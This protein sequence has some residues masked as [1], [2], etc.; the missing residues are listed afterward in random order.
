MKYTST[1]PDPFWCSAFLGLRRFP[2]HDLKK[3]AD[4]V[5]RRV[6]VRQ[7]SLFHR[8]KHFFRGEISHGG[9]FD[10]SKNLGRTLLG[11]PLG[12]T[13]QNSIFR[14]FGFRS[15]RLFAS[16]VGGDGVTRV[17]EAL[18]DMSFFLYPTRRR[19]FSP[20]DFRVFFISPS[21]AHDD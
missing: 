10:F 21:K 4:S 20:F 17:Q 12:K 5:I 16:S 11:L 18:V 19:F 14:R 2:L 3:R 6:L 7:N 8:R 15:Y 1:L 13:C 9:S